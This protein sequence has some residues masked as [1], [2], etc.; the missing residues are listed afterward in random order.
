MSSRVV[1]W[2]HGVD[3]VFIGAEIGEFERVDIHVGVVL[4][5][6]EGLAGLYW[7]CSAL[8][9]VDNA[10]SCWLHFIFFRVSPSYVGISTQM[11]WIRSLCVRI[12]CDPAAVTRLFISSTTEAVIFKSY[13]GTN[14][15][16]RLNCHIAADFADSFNVLISLGCSLPSKLVRNST[17]EL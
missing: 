15:L 13:F 10:L 9:R 17:L 16:S 6:R 14:D 4:E 1:H 2:N 5:E 7:H 12:E 8:L 3:T 11:S